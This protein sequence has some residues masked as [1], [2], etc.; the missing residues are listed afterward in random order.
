VASLSVVYTLSASS[1]PHM[2]SGA[3]LHGEAQRGEWRRRNTWL[4][5][6]KSGPLPLPPQ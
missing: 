2:V 4:K 5:P 1:P 6:P 3:P